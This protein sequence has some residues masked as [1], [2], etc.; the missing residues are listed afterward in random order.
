MKSLD[1]VA[2]STQNLNPTAAYADIVLPKTTTLEEEE[3]QL[4]WG[5]PC[6][7]YT[8][9]VVAARGEARSDIEIAL[10]LRDR[11]KSRNALAQDFLPWANQRA[12]NEFLLGDSGI[13]IEA[14][15]KKGFATFPYEPV[16]YTHLTLPTKA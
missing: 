15:R 6:I 1:F 11:L 7:G 5:G 16:S 14:L 12:F 9:P 3:V 10:E 2:V 8:N 4:I 13:T